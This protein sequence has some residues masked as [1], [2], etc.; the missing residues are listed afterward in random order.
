MQRGLVDE[1]VRRLLTALSNIEE[2][3]S[4]LPASLLPNSFVSEEDPT[5]VFQPLWGN[6]KLDP[7]DF[8]FAFLSIDTEADI[9]TFQDQAG[10]DDDG[11]AGINTLSRL[12]R[13]V[14][15]L[16]GQGPL[17]PFRPSGAGL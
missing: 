2:Q 17:K 8:Q 7:G 14:F 12:D 6:F 15:F 4:S 1:G 11:K 13:I 10:L 5:D 9:R 3:A 16:E